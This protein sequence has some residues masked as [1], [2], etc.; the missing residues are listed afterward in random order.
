MMVMDHEVETIDGQHVSMKNWHGEVLL[1]VNVASACGYT[2]QYKPMQALYER[3]KDRGLVVMGF[4]CNDFGAQEPGDEAEIAEFCSTRY[5]VT[6]PMFAKVRAKAPKSPLYAELTEQAGHHV[7]GE[8]RWNF[9]KFLVGRDGQVLARF[10]PSV[11]PL[12]PTLL[13][14]VERALGEG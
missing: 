13:E 9:T 5:N 7:A 12:D 1:I 10:E 14:A 8:V 4:P 6:F 2:K 11:D 3:Y